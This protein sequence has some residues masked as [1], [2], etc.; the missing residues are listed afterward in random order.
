MPKK[1]DS[2]KD[3]T[4]AEFRCSPGLSCPAV[5]RSEAEGESEYV[6]IGR[7][8]DAS[9][10]ALQGRIGPG[11]I[12]IKISAPLVEGAVAEGKKTVD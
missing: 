10:P 2:L 4:P 1:E 12:A 11:E 6:I 5:F 9:H 3:I 7:I 8:A